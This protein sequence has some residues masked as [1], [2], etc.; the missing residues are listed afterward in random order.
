[1]VQDL[2]CG[3]CLETARPEC[4]AGTCKHCGFKA[5]WQPVRKK[6]VDAYH[7]VRDGV[8]AVWQ[9]KLRYEVL[10][11]GSSTPS[12]G[13]AAD[14]KETLRERKEATIINFLDAF[15]KAC[16]KFPAHRHL[17]GASKAAALQRDRN[18]WIGMLVSDYDWS[19]NGVIASARQIQSEY[20]SLVH[21]SL[22]IQITTYLE[23]DAWLNQRSLL[24]AG[25]EV[26]VQQEGDDF[27]ARQ[28]TK[29]AFYAKVEAAPKDEGEGEL[30]SIKVYGHPT[31]ADGDVIEGVR[32][33]RLRHRKKHTTA[34]V[35]VTDE[36]R[37]DSH[38]TQHFLNCQ[39]QQ[40]LLSLDREQ[41]WAWI[42]HSD[43]ATHFKSGAMM[44]YWSGK[45]SELEFLKMC[46]IDF[47]CPGHGKGPWDG[48]GAVLK[49]YVTRDITNGKILTESGYI[50]CPAEVAEHLRKR[51]GS[52]EWTQAHKDKHIHEIIVF[53]SPHDEIQRPRVDHKFDSLDGSKSSFSYM[54]L[55]QDQIARRT[56]SC[57]CNGCL[58]ARGRINMTCSGD[59][60]ICDECTHRD[61]PVW[62]Q[63][64][65]KDLGTGL[66]GRRKEAQEEGKKFATMLKAPTA[67]KPHE[68]F[69][70]IQDCHPLTS[71]A[72]SRSRALSLMCVLALSLTGPL[73]LCI[74]WQ[75]RERWS[76]AEE[77]HYRP[78][79]FWLA[80]A[81]DIL[82]VRKINERCTIEGVMFSAG[83]YLVRIGRYFDRVASDTSGLTFEEWTPPTGSNF[84]INATE[85]R[86]VNFTMTPIEPGPPLVRVRRS[87]RHV[88]V[89]QAPMIERPKEYVMDSLID[90]Q[91][92]A[93]C[94]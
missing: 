71:N 56:R 12:D 20:W 84:A 51:V 60:L 68:G 80:Q 29:G 67:T 16:I 58:C 43:N 45:M 70:A 47:G 13:S 76:T 64:T 78:G 77:V 87:V 73:L 34:T 79:H 33:E 54:M 63:Q 44:N 57:W 2:V 46:W 30:Y 36:K 18:F 39:F 90:D 23:S 42:G 52:T 92:R 93:R 37:H 31:M 83:D 24:A 48:L 10:K 86:G 62:T 7:K 19:E 35:G 6:L 74:D 27:G 26:T 50:T 49:Q 28:P 94:W 22:F 85:L 72:Q 82:E 1:M 55:A 89:V 66:A 91:I 75:A 59:K 9:S 53:Y 4:V 69:L 41:F 17:V 8:P 38:T 14:E 40:W 5:L 3:G 32:R 25:T 15:E 88:G 81:P 61:A 21:Y 65:V 11:S